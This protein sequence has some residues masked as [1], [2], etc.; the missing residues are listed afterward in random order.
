M[1]SQFAVLAAGAALLAANA[2]ASAH[3]SFAMFDSLHP[4][5]ISGTVKEFRF[6][7]PHTIL[8]V[9]VKGDDGAQKDWILEGGAPEERKK[10]EMAR[11][12]DLVALCETARCRRRTLLAMF[13]EDSA[14]CGHCDVCKGAVRLIDGRIEAD[15]VDGLAERDDPGQGP[16][17]RS[18]DGCG[19]VA[20]RRGVVS[21]AV[22]VHEAL[23]PGLE[24]LADPRPA[25]GRQ[26]GEPRHVGEHPRHRSAAEGA[27]R[28]PERLG[29]AFTGAARRRAGYGAHAHGFERSEAAPGT[30]ASPGGRASG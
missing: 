14:P 28:P 25:L 20:E 6:V 17:G 11:L 15:Q 16:R 18:E 19:R 27:G 29:S 9:T 23:D 24:D 26:V 10:I 5:E 4:K 22:P 1:K 30:S 8:I 13:G 21:E 2:P 3:H 12:D 7:S